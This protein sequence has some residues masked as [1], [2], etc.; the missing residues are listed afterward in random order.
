MF[1]GVKEVASNGSLI[2]LKDMANLAR[3]SLIDKQS[4]TDMEPATLLDCSFSG[5]PCNSSVRT[6][7]TPVLRHL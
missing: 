7:K 6:F 4:A 5:G 2:S 1:P 3:W